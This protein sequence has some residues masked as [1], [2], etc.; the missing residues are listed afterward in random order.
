MEIKR[1]KVRNK[2]MSCVAQEKYET[3]IH[4]QELLKIEKSPAL[5]NYIKDS[6]TK[7]KWAPDVISGTLKAENNELRRSYSWASTYLSKKLNRQERG[8]RRTKIRIPQRTSIHERN[9]IAGQN[10]EIGHF[11]ADLTFHK[12]NQSMNIGSI[13]DKKTQRITLVL[14]SSKHS[15][16]VTAGFLKMI[17]KIPS[18]VR[19]TLTMDNGKEFVSHIA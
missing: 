4:K 15:N 16:T 5:L 13:V 8:K 18:D 19:K 2:Y 9:S 12:G 3:R 17:K 1:N 10:T 11:E 14:N 6:M 7:K